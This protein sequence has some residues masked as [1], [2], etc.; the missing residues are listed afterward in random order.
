MQTTLKFGLRLLIGFLVCL[1]PLPCIIGQTLQ[2]LPTPDAVD[3]DSNDEL[4]VRV[5]SHRNG[6][7]DEERISALEES[8]RQQ[9]EQLNELRKLILEQQET[10][11]LLAGKLTNAELVPGTE[12]TLVLARENPEAR[13]SRVI[14]QAQPTPPLDDRLKS[15]EARVTD[16]RPR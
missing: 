2:V 8:V 10:I 5:A 6:A 4:L 3:V 16:I 13:A 11:E 15:I 9:G 1:I 14:A 7:G 12:N